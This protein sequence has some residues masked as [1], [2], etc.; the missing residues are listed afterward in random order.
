MVIPTPTMIDPGATVVV[1]PLDRTPLH[2]FPYAR[3]GQYGI[4]VEA[5]FSQPDHSLCRRSA[6][7]LAR[8]LYLPNETALN[9]KPFSKHIQE[10][11]RFRRYDF[12]RMSSFV[13]SWCCSVPASASDVCLL[14]L[15]TSF[16]LC[17]GGVKTAFFPSWLRWRSTTAFV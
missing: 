13:E 17:F 6:I 7:P 14:L 2:H 3:D 1:L 16:G 8:A 10:R 4:K 12:R 5:P 11:V 9:H 15:P